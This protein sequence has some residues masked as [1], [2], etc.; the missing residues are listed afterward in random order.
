MELFDAHITVGNGLHFQLEP[1]EL[2]RQMDLYKVSK[3]F[4]SP[5][6]RCMAVAN[7]EGHHYI[8]DLVRTFPERFTGYASINPWYG[9]S[10][11]EILIRALE[12]GLRGIK[13]HPFLQGF[14]LF[15]SIVQPVLEI[16]KQYSAVVYIQ[17]W[18]SINALPL[19]VAE[20][21]RQYPEV[22]FILGRMG[23]TDFAIDAVPALSQAFNL[24][25]ETTYNQPDYLKNLV[26]RFGAERVLF[27]SDSPLTFMEMEIAK[28]HDIDISDSEKELIAHGNLER[29]IS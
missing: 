26:Q 23:K 19:Q 9:K 25:A 17:T 15:D 28:F 6:D 18:S 16:A 29:L 3:A 22:N 12:Q 11:L 24:Y 21:A 13:L 1:V 20:I 2:L 14:T 8:L 5:P 10:G 4:I 27:S 7:E